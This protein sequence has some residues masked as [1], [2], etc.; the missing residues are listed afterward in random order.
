MQITK[1]FQSA[2]TQRVYFVVPP[3][4]TVDSL[5]VVWPSQKKETILAPVT[6]EILTITY[7]EAQTKTPSINTEKLSSE[8][9]ALVEEDFNGDGQ[10][11]IFIGGSRY[12]PA[13]LWIVKK[14]GAYE[15]VDVFAF[16]SDR[17]F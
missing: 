2:S 6:K 11:D 3:D 15:R 4:S 9:P 13:E 17:N 14:K 5:E 12:Q 8:G 7:S 10:N 16:R 1:G